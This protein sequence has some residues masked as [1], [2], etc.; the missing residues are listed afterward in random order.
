MV[1]SLALILVPTFHDF[2]C[3]STNGDFFLINQMFYN[4]VD[5]LWTEITQLCACT[6]YNTI[7]ISISD[8]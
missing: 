3:P 2:Q 7:F 4:Y 8:N 1:S 6:Q 5:F